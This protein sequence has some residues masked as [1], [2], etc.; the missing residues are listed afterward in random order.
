MCLMGARFKW[1]WYLSD[2]RRE[3]KNLTESSLLRKDVVT[4]I[5]PELP[6]FSSLRKVVGEAA[7]PFSLGSVGGIRVVLLFLSIWTLVFA[8]HCAFLL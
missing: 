7:Y 5:V 3:V 2:V 1:P 8:G 6:F 4:V